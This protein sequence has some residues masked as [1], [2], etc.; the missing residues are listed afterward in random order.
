[1]HVKCIGIPALHTI[2]FLSRNARLKAAAIHQCHGETVLSPETANPQG[3]R[4]EGQDGGAKS[5]RKFLDF[6]FFFFWKTLFSFQQIASQGCLQ[7]DGTCASASPSLH[8]LIA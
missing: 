6:F 3:R 5:H 4:R 7:R 1:M 8:P 2:S